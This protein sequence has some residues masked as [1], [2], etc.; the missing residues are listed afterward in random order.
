MVDDAA[1]VLHHGEGELL[2]SDLARG[3]GLVVCLASLAGPVGVLA[4]PRQ[5][6]ESEPFRSERVTVGDVE[7]VVEAYRSTT[8]F[9]HLV[10]EADKRGWRY[11]NLIVQQVAGV[12]S[13]LAKEEGGAYRDAF[14]YF[15]TYLK[16]VVKS[17]D[18]SVSDVDVVIGDGSGKNMSDVP[19]ISDPRK[20]TYHFLI[21]DGRTE[22]GMTVLIGG[23]GSSPA[24]I[25]FT[26]D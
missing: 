25:P 3:V 12:L 2:V 15:G 7:I 22:S 24:A 17:G 6:A 14:L 18:D 11:H 16:V 19:S 10:R 13:F 4:Q 1:K 20:G 26:L 21:Q 8:G 5:D 9:S 23:S